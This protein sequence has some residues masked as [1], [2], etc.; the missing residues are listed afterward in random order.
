M[1]LAVLR[2]D[3]GEVQRS[4]LNDQRVAL[5]VGV[6]ATVEVVDVV[7]TLAQ[8]AVSNCSTLVH[9]NHEVVHLRTAQD[10][11]IAVL[12]IIGVS[13][14]VYLRYEIVLESSGSNFRIGLQCSYISRHV[15]ILGFTQF[16]ASLPEVT[17]HVDLCTGNATEAPRL[18]GRG[19]A[20][21]LDE[22]LLI[23]EFC[24]LSLRH[25]SNLVVAASGKCSTHCN[26]CNTCHQILFHH[27][28][29]VLIWF[30][31]LINMF[32]IF[33]ILIVL[34]AKIGKK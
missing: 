30:I 17:V 21:L 24:L 4:T 28:F 23:L 9:G 12:V 33:V 18:V 1:V 22:G 3:V 8:H 34:G 10:R 2:A 19:L 20:E 14:A 13:T 29:N 16:G 11:A 31:I 7:P 32:R 25:R 26:G 5:P 27:F 15:G 6:I